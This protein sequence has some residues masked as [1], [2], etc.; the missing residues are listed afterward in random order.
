MLTLYIISDI[1]M[2]QIPVTKHKYHILHAV[3]LSFFDF[4]FS[5]THKMLSVM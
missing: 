2:Y 3:E 1:S 5:D 4:R